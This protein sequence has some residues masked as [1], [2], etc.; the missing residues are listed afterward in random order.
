MPIFQDEKCDNPLLHLIK[1]QIHVWRLKVEWHEGCLT[2]MFMGT[3]EGKA[4]EWYE[5]LKLGSLFF[6]KRYPQGI[7]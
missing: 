3:L 4:R 6:P 1:F 5:W 2:K 7:L